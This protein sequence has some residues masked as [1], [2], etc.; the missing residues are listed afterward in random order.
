MAA[1]RSGI[2]ANFSRVFT[3]GSLDLRGRIIAIYAIL[4]GFHLLT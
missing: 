2:F 1:E 4:I 3:T